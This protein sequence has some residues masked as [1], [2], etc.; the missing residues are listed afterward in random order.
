MANFLETNGP[1]NQLVDINN[2]KI[3]ELNFGIKTNYL[4][5]ISVNFT[6]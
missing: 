5:N 4:N 1:W 6:L 2:I 3:Q